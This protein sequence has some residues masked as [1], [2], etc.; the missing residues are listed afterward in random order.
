MENIK[1]I[2]DSDAGL[3]VDNTDGG[4]KVVDNRFELL[5]QN[6]DL[7][8]DKDDNFYSELIGL[9]SSYL[10]KFYDSEI[11]DFPMTVLD[12][13]GELVSQDYDELTRGDIFLLRRVNRE[14]SQN[15][16]K[17]V[18]EM[19]EKKDIKLDIETLKR[20]LNRN[21]KLFS[22]TVDKSYLYRLFDF[23]KLAKIMKENQTLKKSN[24]NI[25]DF[26]Q[27]LIDTCQIDNDEVFGCLIEP[28]EFKENHQK[29]DELLNECNS[30]AFAT[31]TG[32]IM[33]FFD[34]DYDALSIIKK[35]KE[36]DFLEEV[37]IG[38]LKSSFKKSTYD[39]VHQLLTDESI[40]IDYDYYWFDYAGQTS[41]KDIIAFSSNR[42]IINDLLSDEK[43]IQ[44]Y[45]YHGEACVPLFNL[46]AI[47]GEYEKA[48]ENF[49]K[50][51][52]YAH[53]FTEDFSDGFNEKGYAYGGWQYEDYLVEF[54]RKIC[55][56][57]K[58][59]V[60][61]VFEA[62]DFINRILINEKIEYINLE[63]VLPLVQEVL[64]DDDFGTLLDT[65]TEKYDAG[66]LKFIVVND[67]FEGMFT[68]YIIRVATE[69]EVND[70]LSQFNKKGETKVLNLKNKCNKRKGD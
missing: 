51:H 7:V 54:I 63:E 33:N 6:V 4:K 40:N 68:R 20:L 70:T 23:H 19:L 29:I 48:L 50:R 34:K 49:Q 26:Y 43:N 55:N 32:I 24:I 38:L 9:I 57:F 16:F 47:T 22:L 39:L 61:N 60:V 30:D 31:I 45:Y 8:E 67:H 15:L 25:N 3:L 56:S 13:K 10:S 18:C 66:N 5:K 1:K 36:N 21:P 53:G 35:R 65:L 69:G 62:K 64:S 2:L 59:E 44:N 14:L 11:D 37:I 28:E 27:L 12:E 46:Y 42:T 58:N 17:Y 41:L 52:N